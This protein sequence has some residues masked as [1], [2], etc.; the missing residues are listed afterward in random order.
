M[1]CAVDIYTHKEMRNRGLAKAL[2]TEMLAAYSGYDFVYAVEHEDNKASEKL[3]R[4][5]G[6]V[7]IGNRAQYIIGQ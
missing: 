1:K 3:A 2:L 4:S 6:F 5:C 7:H